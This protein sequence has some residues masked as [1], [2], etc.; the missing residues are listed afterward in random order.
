[1]NVLNIDRI[2][3][4]TAALAIVG[5]LLVTAPARAQDVLCEVISAGGSST[6]DGS[7]FVFGQLATGVVSDASDEVDQGVIPC[8]RICPGDINGD[9]V[10]DLSDLAIL[11]SNFGTAAGAQPS[12][13]D[14]D[15]DGDVDLS[16]LAVMLSLFGTFCP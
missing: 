9:G 15:G 12:D 8:W 1:M 10:I 11:L 6:N 2:R 16:D 7:I 14:I 13:G 4:R 5:L 3:L